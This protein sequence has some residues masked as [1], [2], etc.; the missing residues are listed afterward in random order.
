MIMLEFSL[1]QSIAILER[2]PFV[3]EMLLRDLPEEWTTAKESEST[4][5]P[6]DVVGHF[7]HGEKT[8]WIPRMKIILG[9]S[10]NGK[11]EPF[12][13]FAQFHNSKGKTLSELL[14]EF[15][16]R[17]KTNVELLRS[18]NITPEL[19]EWT[20]IHPEFGTITLR[21]L[22]A[23]WVVHDLNHLGQIV[24]VMAKQYAAEVG[25]WAAYLRIV[26]S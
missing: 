3:L 17:R 24:R 15:K 22:L 5:S 12:D 16:I 21:Q 26:N 23:T 11:F 13:R 19:L 1:E 20:G 10:K 7:I 9:G 2:T 14:I 4:W 18:A 25:P 8:D 6:Y